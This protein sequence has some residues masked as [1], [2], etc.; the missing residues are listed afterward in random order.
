MPLTQVEIDAI[1]TQSACF[2]AEIWGSKA[3]GLCPDAVLA[4]CRGVPFRCL[5]APWYHYGPRDLIPLFEED[6]DIMNKVADDLGAV[7]GLGDG[8]GYLDALEEEGAK[9]LDR[10]PATATATQEL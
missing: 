1:R 9:I 10:L 2:S 3:Q 4:Q 6:W 5:E 7:M 8:F